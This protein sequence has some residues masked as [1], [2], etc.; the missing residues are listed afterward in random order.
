MSRVNQ[1]A[2]RTT[3]RDAV[4]AA[5]FSLIE[6]MMAVLILGLGLLGLG[7]IMPVVVK[8]Q[9]IGA[10][11]V[12]G[13]MAANSALA[14]LEGTARLRSDYFNAAESIAIGKQT[15]PDFWRNWAETL[16]NGTNGNTASQNNFTN[17]LPEDGLWFVARVDATG[18]IAIGP[19]RTA[20]ANVNNG[21]FGVNPVR[22]SMADRLYPSPSAGT[23]TLD[24]GLGAPLPLP[25]EL[26]SYVAPSFVYDVAARRLVARDLRSNPRSIPEA[27]SKVQ[28]AIFVRRVDPEIRVSNPRPSNP[29]DLSASTTLSRPFALVSALADPT[30]PTAARRWPVSEDDGSASSGS[31]GE[32]T[33]DG[34]FD[35]NGGR[36]S[37]IL[38]LRVQFDPQDGTWPR[39]RIVLEDA[40]DNPNQGNFGAGVIARNVI[41]NGQRIVDNF[42]NVYR[43]VGQD[44]RVADPNAMRVDPPVPGWVGRTVGST[45]GLREVL[46]TLQPPVAIVVKTM[47]P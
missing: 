14:V 26:R 43:V 46:A 30:I 35:G 3:G 41:Q 23:T 33:L 15:S 2:T 5:A 39:D 18:A 45:S 42:G 36:Y 40:S 47:N 1:T 20:G 31:A 38:R 32:P 37:N 21:I 11:A 8:Q 27:S 6:V 9:R 10:D 44:D 7:A 4:R 13:T 16:P 28:V 19:S 24:T 12:Q 34:R 17:L 29:A 22:I 25:E